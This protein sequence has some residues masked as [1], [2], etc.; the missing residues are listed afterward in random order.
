[1]FR[2]TTTG[3]ASA[4]GCVLADAINTMGLVL[5]AVLGRCNLHRIVSYRD[6]IYSAGKLVELFDFLFAAAVFLYV[7]AK[8]AIICY[9]LVKHQMSRFPWSDGACIVD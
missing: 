5:G 8:I 6:G 4:V 1:M 3:V 2:S 7:G 9:D